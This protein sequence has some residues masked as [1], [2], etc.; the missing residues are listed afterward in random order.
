MEFDLSMTMINALL[1]RISADSTLAERLSTYSFTNGRIL[2]PD[3][4]FT[5]EELDALEQIAIE[6][7]DR[8]L[9]F[10]VIAARQIR[11]ETPRYPTSDLATFFKDIKTYLSENAIDGWVYR[12]NRDGVML[13]WYINGIE[14][15]NNRSNEHGGLLYV[16]IQLLAN[17]QAATTPVGK[18]QPTSGIPA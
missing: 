7:E 11:L 8:A 4:L 5:P 18:S 16:A 6:T 2:V 12:R 3:N 14:Y 9:R 10:Q 17:T 13:P 15:I 1:A